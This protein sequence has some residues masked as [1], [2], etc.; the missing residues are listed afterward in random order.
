MNAKAVSEQ[1]YERKIQTYKGKE[2]SLIQSTIGTKT[3]GIDLTNPL[4]TVETVLN[5]LTNDSSN[6]LL[7]NEVGSIDQNLEHFIQQFSNV[8]KV[9]KRDTSTYE[10]MIGYLLLYNILEADV[11]GEYGMG[12]SKQS[13][14]KGMK[15]FF[16]VVLDLNSLNIPSELDPMHWMYLQNNAFYL[17]PTGYYRPLVIRTVDRVVEIKE[18]LFYVKIQDYNF[19]TMAHGANTEINFDFDKYKDLPFEQWPEHTKP[20]IEKELP[21]YMLVNQKGEQFQLY[22]QSYLPLIN[23]EIDEF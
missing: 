1:Q 9:D 19:D 18:N 23:E 10:T 4:L 11:P 2:L 6:T 7:T 17:V 16:D 3:F 14:V 22:Y 13:V 5:N 20:Y 12:Y 21:T 8:G 15:D